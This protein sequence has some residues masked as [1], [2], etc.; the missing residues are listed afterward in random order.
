M[1]WGLLHIFQWAGY[2]SLG[3]PD[4]LQVVATCVLLATIVESLPVTCW[5]DDNISVPAT[6][7][8]AAAWLL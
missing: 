8:A 5:L 1:T 3:R 7:A 6:A 2:L 4:L